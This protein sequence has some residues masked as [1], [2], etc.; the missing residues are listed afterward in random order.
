MPTPQWLVEG[1][2]EKNSLVM[3]AGPPASY[4]SFMAL[5]WLMCMVTGR[6]WYGRAVAP[7]KV[8]YALGEGKASL[9]KRIKSWCHHHGAAPEEMVKVNEN[10]RIVFDVPQLALRPSLDNMLSGLAT[11]G[12]EPTVL[13]ID[14]LARS[15]V[16]MDENSQKDTGLWV[17]GAERLR[18]AGYTVIT[19]H[20]TKKNVETGIQYRGSTVLMGAMDTG[21]TMVKSS[22]TVTLTVTKQKDHDEGE[23]LTFNRVIVK[24]DPDQEG[25]IVLVPTI[26]RD[27][28]FMAEDESILKALLDDATFESDRARARVL[29][30]QLG[31]TEGAAQTRISRRRRHCA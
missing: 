21:M 7:S 2:F 1:L 25:S 20:H 30:E 17:E 14:T 16:G 18:A 31:I 29:A 4:K 19:V 13:I 26:Q 27:T 6:P 12:F 23:P 10:L 11:E 28:R 9:L 3:L 8:L 24:P 15:F 5:D 22:G